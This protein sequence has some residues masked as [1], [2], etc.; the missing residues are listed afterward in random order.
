MKKKTENG[1]EQNIDPRHAEHKD[2]IVSLMEDH[3]KALEY[4]AIL[5][6][7][8]DRIKR[9]GFSFEAYMEISDAILFIETQI[10]QHDRKE[11]E[12]LFPLLARYL[13]DSPNTLRYEHRELWSAMAQLNAIVKDVADGNIHGSSIVE[14]TNGAKTVAE[15]L[16]HH[17]AKEN[18]L[19]PMIKETVSPKE[20]E[21]L[22]ED[23]REASNGDSLIRRK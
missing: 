3:E 6:E 14:L 11:E 8:A 10:R 19:F 9:D 16:E 13:P 21:Q 5:R 20:Y 1:E 2:P 17:I 15:L 12:H 22:A 7:A 18:S 4:T 23:L